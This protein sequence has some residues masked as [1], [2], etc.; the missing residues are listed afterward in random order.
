MIRPTVPGSWRHCRNGVT[1]SSARLTRR[2]HQHEQ[3]PTRPAKR[4]SLPL[5]IAEVSTGGAF[6]ARRAWRLWLARGAGL[7]IIAVP[8]CLRST[9]AG[10]SD[11]TRCGDRHKI[12]IIPITSYRG[13]E[14]D[15]SLSPDG[16]QLAF[17]WEGESGDD[18]DIYVKLVDGG[19]PV[20]LTTHRGME[21]APVWSPDGR[22]IAFLREVGLF[23]GRLSWSCRHSPEVP[24]RHLTE[25]AANPGSRIRRWGANW[26]VWV[27]TG[28]SLV[29][30]DEESPASGSRI[31]M[32]SVGVL[33]A[34]A[35]H[36]S[37][38]HVWR[39]RAGPFSRVV[40]SSRSC[41]AVPARKWGRYSCRTW[42]ERAPWESRGRR[43]GDKRGVERDV[44]PRRQRA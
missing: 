10:F 26:L 28:E 42:L 21:R 29:F 4:A 22:R 44:D 43:A 40:T 27:P 20:Q 34:P 6:K 41:A 7:L 30:A 35:T 1:G 3:P 8:R 13:L 11:S 31:F 12:Q 39:H 14:V 15:P 9:E 17:A 25:V 18:L 16:N 37:G 23:H 32:C 38:G 5:P 33:R 19:T 2:R 24:E 36:A